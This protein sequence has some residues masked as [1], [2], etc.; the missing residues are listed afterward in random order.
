MKRIL[1]AV[2]I[3][4]LAVSSLPG[5]KEKVKPGTA[6]VKR[7]VV[8]GV[9]I[10][11]VGLRQIE[12]AYETTGTVKAKAL[13]VIAARTMG[14]VV[15][16]SV[17]EGDRVRTGQELVVLDA[18]DMAQRLAAADSGHR[19]A[20]KALDEA[21]QQR[22]LADITYRR[23]KNLAEEKVISQQEMDEV[24]TRKKVADLAY[25]RTAESVNR[26]RARME[27]A[28]IAKGFAHITAPHDGVVTE[29][30]IEP[31]SM[32]VPGA[33][34]LTLED[35]SS[36][37][38]DAYVNEGMLGKLKRGTAVSILLP[39]D[40]RRIAGAIGE[41]VPAV[42]PAT[43]SFPIKIY[44]K[45]ASLRSGLYVKV[46]I[47]EGKK[48]ALLVPSKALVE[49]GLL[50]GVYVVDGQGVVTYRVVRTGQAY[51]EDVQV[52]SGLKPGERVVTAGTDRAVDGGI[53]KQ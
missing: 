14:S 15:S 43:R 41:I 2:S 38:I 44:L 49:K 52:V 53:V 32:A 40:G 37:R 48:D 25:E 28:R 24:E 20:L 36:Y 34:L 42:D 1:V 47:P 5:C 51:G 18:R 45:E 22:S 50:T 16:V 30:K 46:A 29:K 6:A 8:S 17:R 31:G 23:Y 19:E 12:S 10:A 11:P 39:G 33:P 3:V 21:R 35:T 9:T 26:A 27:E 7:P 13:S 4:I